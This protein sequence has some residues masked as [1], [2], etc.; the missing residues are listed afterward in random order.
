[1]VVTAIPV[2]VASTG[3]L[4]PARTR[5]SGI[6]VAHADVYLDEESDADEAVAYPEP[7]EI[8]WKA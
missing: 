8:N 5:H 6:R 1:M 3:E 2:E 4:N 7:I